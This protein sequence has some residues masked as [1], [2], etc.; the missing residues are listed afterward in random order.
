MKLCPCV[1]GAGMNDAAAAVER[2]SFSHGAVRHKG[3]HVSTA[4]HL[5]SWNR[6]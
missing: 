1:V 5:G 2:S 4:L 6:D 3:N